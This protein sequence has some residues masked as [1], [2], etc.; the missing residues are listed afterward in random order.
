MKLQVWLIGVL[1]NSWFSLSLSFVFIRD[2][3]DSARLSRDKS[4]RPCQSLQNNRSSNPRWSSGDCPQHYRRT[5]FGNPLLL[6]SRIGAVCG[7][8][9]C[10]VGREFRYM[11]NLIGHRDDRTVYSRAYILFSSPDDLVNFHKG[12]DGH[13]FR[14]KAGEGSLRCAPLTNWYRI[15]SSS[16]ILPGAEDTLQNQSEERC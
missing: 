2:G 9:S 10:R 13:V 7:N 1:Q 14:S 6:G 8:A 11:M 16:R 5:S 12:F 15:S 3:S 4:S